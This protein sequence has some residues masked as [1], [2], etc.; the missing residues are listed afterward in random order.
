MNRLGANMI[1]STCICS[2]YIYMTKIPNLL[3]YLHIVEHSKE[4]WLK[5]KQQQ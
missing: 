1:F 3:K 5:T 2:V 4:H